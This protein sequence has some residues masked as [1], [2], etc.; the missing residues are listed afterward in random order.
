MGYAQKPAAR[1]I[2]VTGRRDDVYAEMKDVLKRGKG[3]EGEK[4][5]TNVKNLGQAMR[6]EKKGSGRDACRLFASE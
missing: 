1:G 2:N 6:D 4:Y 3:P 5:R